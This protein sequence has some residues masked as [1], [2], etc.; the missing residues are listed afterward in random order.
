MATGHGSLA[1]SPPVVPLVLPLCS[2]STRS[3]T[4]VLVSRTTP[5]PPREEETASSTVSLMSTARPSSLTVL[6]VSTEVSFPLLSVSSSTV[7]STSVFTT[8]SV[9]IIS[10][11]S[12]PLHIL[13][14]LVEPVV[15]VGALEGSFLAS[16]GLGWGVTIGAGLASYPLDTIR[17]RMMMTSGG[18]VHYKSMFDAGSQII[19]KEGTKSL[20]KGAGANI[21]RGVAGAGVLSLY[22]KLQQVMFG[23]VYSGGGYPSPHLT[24]SEMLTYVFRIWLNTLISSARWFSGMSRSLIDLV[25]HPLSYFHI[26]GDILLVPTLDTR[27]EPTTQK[28]HFP[29]RDDGYERAVG[30]TPR[31]PTVKADRRV[32]QWLTNS[33]PLDRTT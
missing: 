29:T 20:F 22:D 17:R 9:S 25:P 18:T 23:K 16:F 5:S 14:R 10:F 28:Y 3:I 13:M 31:R 19:A 33:V 1:T 32:T 24:S 6:P 4:L 27:Y 2:S 11:L 21:L 30:A 26:P 8:R 15:L 7:V 12:L